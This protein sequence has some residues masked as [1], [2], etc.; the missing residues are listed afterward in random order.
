MSAAEKG[1]EQ[2]PPLVVEA[3]DSP[4]PRTRLGRWFAK[5]PKS[6]RVLVKI[7][8]IYFGV[9]YILFPGLDSLRNCLGKH[10]GCH[11][12]LAGSDNDGYLEGLM[13][14][15]WKVGYPGPRGA[16]AFHGEKD[17]HRHDHHHGKDKYRP[18]PIGPREAERIF[19]S[20]PNNVS[21]R[22]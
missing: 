17:H 9:C 14:R 5:Q 10:H 16:E 11:G 21:A 20:T 2:E 15:G 13:G 3:I 18:H 12:E 19:L 22:A 6:T 8:V 7:L 1:E 4:Q